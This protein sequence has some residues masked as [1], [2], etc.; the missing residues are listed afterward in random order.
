MSLSMSEQ[1]EITLRNEI[2]NVEL[3]A[4]CVSHTAF[5]ATDHKLFVSFTD[6]AEHS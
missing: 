5:R 1:R 3:T 6:F 2:A 4:R